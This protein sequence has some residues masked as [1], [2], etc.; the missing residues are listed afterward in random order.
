MEL[1]K[2]L[3]KIPKESPE[4]IPINLNF[5]PKGSSSIKVFGGYIYAFFLLKWELRQTLVAFKIHEEGKCFYK[6]K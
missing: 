6:R 1:S 3:N 4:F 5:I 2:C